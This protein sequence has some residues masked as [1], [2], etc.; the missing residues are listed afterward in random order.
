MMVV[1]EFHLLPARRALPR[2]SC[3][4]FDRYDRGGKSGGGPAYL[5]EIDEQ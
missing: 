3:L 2:H 4:Q 5:V 1:F